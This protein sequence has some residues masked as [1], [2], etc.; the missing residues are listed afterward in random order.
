MAKLAARED[1]VEAEY[2]LIEQQ[3]KDLDESKARLEA[4]KES[5]LHYAKLSDTVKL[6]IG[7]QAFVETRRTTLCQC[8]DS[9]L[10]SLVSGR[11]ENQI[12]YDGEG[13]IFIDFSP[14]A[15]L[16]LLRFMREIQLAAPDEPVDS[17]M[18]PVC[19]HGEFDHMSRFFGV[20][21]FICSKTAR[22]LESDSARK[23]LAVVVNGN[24]V[25]NTCT[26][27][28]NSSIHTKHGFTSVLQDAMNTAHEERQ[29]RQAKIAR[30]AEF[31]ASQV[32]AK[33]L[34]CPEDHKLAVQPAEGGRFCDVCRR[35]IGIECATAR[36][37]PC[38]F[39]LCERC[40]F[41]YSGHE[42]QQGHPSKQ[43][44]HASKSPRSLSA[45]V[46]GDGPAAIAAHG[47]SSITASFDQ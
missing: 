17:P 12:S 41:L 37:D 21:K 2:K 14:D 46:A 23:G 11:W 7:G 13:R 20:E 3:Q 19:A 33:G 35:I 15:F 39:D 16:P 42:T 24:R 44:V 25:S 43:I 45:N 6:N 4:E 32:D 36:C 47:T 26:P 9:L 27:N 8:P 38:Q 1:K 30:R 29:S 34:T 10:C 18:V 40:I 5:M 31:I 22:T 28:A